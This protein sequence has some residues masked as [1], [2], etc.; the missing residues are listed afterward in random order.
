MLAYVA[1]CRRD[2]FAILLRQWSHT[3]GTISQRL[4]VA[5]HTIRERIHACWFGKAIGGTLGTPFEGVTGPLNL[6]FYEPV[7]T[8]A[9]PNDDLDLQIVWLHHLRKGRHHE[10]TPKILAEAWQR[11]VL[12]PFDEYGIARRNHALGLSGPRQGASD[13]FFGECMGGAIRSEVWACIAPG[14]PARAAGF[15]WMDGVVDH[16]GDGVWAEVFNAA[17]QSAAFVESDP[18]R[19]IDTALS[20]LPETSRVKQAVR[21]SV[22]WWELDRDWRKVRQ[23]VLE[24]YDTGNFTQVVCNISFQI[25]GWLDGGGDFGRSICTAVNCGLDTDCT[26]ATLGALL[27]ILNPRSLPQHWRDPIGE[28]VVLSPPIIGVPVPRDLRELTDWTIEVAEQLRDCRPQIGYIPGHSPATPETAVQTWPGRTALVI[29]SN[30]PDSPTLPASSWDKATTLVL[31][32]AWSTWRCSEVGPAGRLI[33]IEI[34]VETEGCY[35]LMAYGRAGVVAWMDGNRVLSY[36]ARELGEDTF[37][38]PSFHRAG[39]AAVVLPVLS[40]GMHRLAIWLKPFA[41]ENAMD[42]VW[43]LG[44]PATNLWATEI[45][46]NDRHAAGTILIDRVRQIPE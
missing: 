46:P 11:H 37:A 6:T 36:A 26:G 19:L 12:F 3:N 24:R 10:V 9:L 14:D 5:D 2:G 18:R 35:K 44:D 32:G 13:N 27:G 29:D 23:R 38:A 45:R 40:R 41:S 8:Q 20:F 16:A 28:T 21:D 30:M 22:A 34:W 7:P 33:E 31:S 25:I 39:V 4:F 1:G 15:A 17:L 43:G 42:L